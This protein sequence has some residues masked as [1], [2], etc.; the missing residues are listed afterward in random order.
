[1]LA[2][3]APGK[4]LRTAVSQVKKFLV[5]QQGVSA[6]ETEK[7]AALFTP[8]LTAAL[9]PSLGDKAGL[10]NVR[11]LRTLAELLDLL[12]KGNLTGLGDLLAQRFKAEEMAPQDGNWSVSRHL[13]LLGD[14]RVS[15]T[16]PRERELAQL[17]ERHDLKMK[18][19]RARKE[20]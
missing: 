4:P 13:E 20:E 18:G 16:T 1:M 12:I 14:S 11:E 3:R 9:L 10:R 7:L 5:G 15:M 6:V 19:F 2:R 8:H 17:A